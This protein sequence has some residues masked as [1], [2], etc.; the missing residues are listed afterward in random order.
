MKKLLALV[1]VLFLSLT[2][3]ADAPPAF[4]P[5]LYGASPADFAQACEEALADTTLAGSAVAEKDGMPICEKAQNRAS[6]SI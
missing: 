5:A 2:A 4:A 1:M 3:L 6:V